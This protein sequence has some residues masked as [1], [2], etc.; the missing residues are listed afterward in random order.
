M[1]QIVYKPFLC[2]LRVLQNFAPNWP[3]C[4]TMEVKLFQL[5]LTVQLTGAAPRQGSREY[6][7]SPEALTLGCDSEMSA[8]LAVPPPDSS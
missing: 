1:H 5:Q 6:R 2:K 3:W 8:V 4:L 7:R